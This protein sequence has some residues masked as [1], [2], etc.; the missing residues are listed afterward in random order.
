MG[1]WRD[2]RSTLWFLLASAIYR[3][4][5]AGVFTFGAIIAAVAFGF[6]PTEVI[7]F[8]IAANLVAGVATLFAGMVDDWIGPRRLILISLTGMVIAGLAVAFLHEAGAIVF[9]VGGLML[10]LFV[11]PVQAASRSLLARVSPPG[12]EGEIFGL[13]ATT[14]RA[15]SFLAPLLWTLAIALTGATIWGVVGIITVV[16]L[17]LVAMLFVKVPT[18]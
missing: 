2:A 5:L 7:I 11:G 10:C 6:E 4:G 8:G 18:G 17:G 9:W 12:R 16:A 14:G 1:L 15:V 3:D 13:Y